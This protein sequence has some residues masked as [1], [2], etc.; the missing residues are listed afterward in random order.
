MTQRLDV[1]AIDLKDDV[2]TMRRKIL[3]SPH[4]RLIVS[5]GSADQVVG[6]F[7]PSICSTRS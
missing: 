6:W 4:S 3:A 7:R 5:D 1:D 2:A